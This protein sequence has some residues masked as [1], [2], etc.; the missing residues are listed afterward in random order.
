MPVAPPGAT[1]T[2]GS[3][4][5]RR[6]D[7]SAWR[8][9]WL[10]LL[11][12]LSATCWLLYRHLADLPMNDGTDDRSRQRVWMYY[13][14]HHT[15]TWWAA[16]AAVLGTS[17][18]CAL[19]VVLLRSGVRHLVTRSKIAAVLVAV[20]GW[21]VWLCGAGFLALLSLAVW[22]VA[23]L[24]GDQTRVAGP[25]RVHVLVTRSDNGYGPQ[26]DVW[27]QETSTRYVWEPG[28]ATVDP[29]RGRCAVTSSGDELVLSCGTTSQT[30][31]R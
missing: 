24:E 15:S 12:L 27:R 13:W 25:R 5:R 8:L 16:L 7:S 17:S 20:V 3:G 18:S 10:A 2:Y 30:L 26:V 6:G 31:R 11:T 28:D 21:T 4:E 23:D 19:A 22:L 29:E 1:V 9:G 14:A